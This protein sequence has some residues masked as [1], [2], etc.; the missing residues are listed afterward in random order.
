MKILSSMLKT[1]KTVFPAA[2]GAAIFVTNAYTDDID[3]SVVE[4][5]VTVQT[6]DP[7]MPWR[8][9]APKVRNGFAV[10]IA[11]G[12]AITTENL[13]R[14]HV[15]VELRRA[16]AGTKTAVRVAEADPQTGAAVL[17]WENAPDLANLTP[18]ALAATIPTNA[19]VTIVQFND[20][21]QIQR[22]QARITE[23]AVA[24]LP[25]SPGTL[26]MFRALTSLNTGDRGAPVLYRN[27]LA[28]LVLQSDRNSQT[29]RIL[30]SAVLHRFLEDTCRPPYRGVAVAGFSWAALVDPVKRAFRGMEADGGGIEVVHTL[31]GS[32]ADGVLQPGDVI[33]AWDGADLDAQGYYDDPEFGR[34]LLP[35]LING[36]RRP[37]D[38]VTLTILR[39]GECRDIQFTISRRQDADALIPEN[40]ALE[41]PEYLVDCGLIFRELGGDVLRGAGDKWML[42][43]N[44][45]L[46][47]LYLTRSQ[48]PERPGDHVVILVGILPDPVNI[49]Y[50]HI[51]DGVVTAVNGQP[52]RCLADLFRI[53]DRDGGLRR[54]TLQACDQDIV[55][56]PEARDEANRRLAEVYRI[57]A[58]RYR[59]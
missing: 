45:R 16:R 40:M 25:D 48:D 41:Q 10:V 44:P 19:E 28:G 36:R 11:P 42:R 4:V 31:P 51:R 14:D 55:L 57:P 50:Q 46:V 43:S 21:G 5:Q 56:D 53:M 17:A 27:Q 33:L 47:Y 12:R 9:D 15:M 18:I 37:G 3:R 34:L 13:V 20:T 30:P 26:L 23:V 7:F 35:Y 29:C 22:D 59:K 54:V 32:G 2:L 24:P 49:G 38:T 52:I 6:V 8:R 58:L 1:W 39:D